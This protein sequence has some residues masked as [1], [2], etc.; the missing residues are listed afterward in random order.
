MIKKDAKRVHELLTD[1]LKKYTVHQEFS[2]EEVVKLLIPKDGVI[3]S[4]VIE[5]EGIITDFFSFYSL[6][7]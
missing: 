1:N 4:Y 7:S 5:N 3:Y 2:Y 6:P